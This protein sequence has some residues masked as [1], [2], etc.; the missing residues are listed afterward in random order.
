MLNKFE[1]LSIEQSK[2]LVPARPDGVNLVAN[3]TIPNPS[4]LELQI[5]RY[6][7]ILGLPIFCP[8][9]IST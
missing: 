8:C 1:G 3:A 5:V 2:L 4:V 7:P 9:S 6:K